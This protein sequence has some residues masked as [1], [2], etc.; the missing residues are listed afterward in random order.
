EDA[1]LLQVIRRHTHLDVAASNNLTGAAALGGDWTLEIQQG[2]IE[3]GQ[4]FSSKALQD[5]AAVLQPFGTK[6]F[7]GWENEAFGDDPTKDWDGFTTYIATE[8][9]YEELLS[10]TVCANDLYVSMY[11]AASKFLIRAIP[12]DSS[13]GVTG[14]RIA[15]PD[16][17]GN[18]ATQVS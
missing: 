11:D 5:F 8:G 6:T 9:T 12:Q 16:R 10:G 4:P 3:T 15:T 1:E 18:P 17:G 2:N 13:F 7:E 14:L